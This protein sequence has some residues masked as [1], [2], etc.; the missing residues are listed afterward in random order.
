MIVILLGNRVEFMDYFQAELRRSFLPSG[1]RRPRL[2]VTI[3]DIL[4][5]SLEGVGGLMKECRWKCFKWESCEYIEDYC[6]VFLV[7][8]K[9]ARRQSA[10]PSL[11]DA[12][13]DE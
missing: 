2:T 7:R 5:D 8:M 4:P 10:L 12:F 13:F 9:R 11:I 6:E 1:L 3:S